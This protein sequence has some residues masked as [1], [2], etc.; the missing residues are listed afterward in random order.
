MCQVAKNPVTE[1]GAPGVYTRGRKSVNDKVTSERM[2]FFLKTGACGD[3]CARRT[4]AS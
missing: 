4:G 1:W 2:F 3:E